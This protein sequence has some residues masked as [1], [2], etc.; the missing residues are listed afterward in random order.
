MAQ[1]LV[2][3]IHQEEFGRGQSPHIP[4]SVLDQSR[5]LSILVSL[6]SNSFFAQWPAFLYIVLHAPCLLRFASTP[7]SSVKSN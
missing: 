1:F 3:L 4:L 5:N 7:S 6:D 2:D